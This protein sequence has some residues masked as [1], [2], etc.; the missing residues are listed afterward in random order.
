[1]LVYHIIFPNSSWGSYAPQE[2]LITAGD[3]TAAEISSAF[4]KRQVATYHVIHD[5]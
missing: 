5:M 3:S 1:M 2:T 4:L